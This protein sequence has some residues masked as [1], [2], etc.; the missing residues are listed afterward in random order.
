MSPYTFELELGATGGDGVS[1]TSV[2]APGVALSR[3]RHANTA[4]ATKSTRPI[5]PPTAPPISG[6]LSLLVLVEIDD[7]SADH[8]TVSNVKNVAIALVVGVGGVGVVVFGVVVLV[9]VVRLVV[10]VVAGFGFAQTTHFD[11]LDNSRSHG[12]STT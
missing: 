4:S 8:G 10:V 2:D 6:A 11:L 9:V 3:L 5:E 7:G 12:R 1:G